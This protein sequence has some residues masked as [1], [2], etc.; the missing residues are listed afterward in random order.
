MQKKILQITLLFI[1]TFIAVGQ[2]AAMV[3]CDEAESGQECSLIP[4]EELVELEAQNNR[5]D[6]TVL[7]SN[8]DQNANGVMLIHTSKLA[9]AKIQI[10]AKKAYQSPEMKSF[11]SP[12]F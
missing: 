9:K 4:T 10:V 11:R 8:G 5:G 12:L 3:S 2:A 1:I 6:A 7:P